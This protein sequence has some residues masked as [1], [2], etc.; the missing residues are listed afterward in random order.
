MPDNVSA[1]TSADFW[2]ASQYR[3]SLAHRF[4]VTDLVT[5][6][7][8]TPEMDRMSSNLRDAN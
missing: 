1:R 4:L 8:E 5:K 6:L 7:C 2:S 3:V